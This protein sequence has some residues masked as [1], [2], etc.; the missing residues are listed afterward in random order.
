MTRLID[1]DALLE[2]RSYG[3]GTSGDDFMRPFYWADDL[4]AA[5]TVSCGECKWYDNGRRGIGCRFCYCGDEF[6]RREP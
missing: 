4:D 2:P 6:E 1:A 3:Q 5:A